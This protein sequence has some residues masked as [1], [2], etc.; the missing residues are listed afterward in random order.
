MTNEQRYNAIYRLFDRMINELEMDEQR[1]KNNM[2]KHYT[3]RTEY[4]QKTLEI[5]IRKKTIEEVSKSVLYL[6]GTDTTYW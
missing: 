3:S 2:I 5:E 1:A 6:I 4:L